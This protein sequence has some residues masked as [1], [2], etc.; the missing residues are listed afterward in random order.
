[1]GGQASCGREAVGTR[2]SRGL[3]LAADSRRNSIRGKPSCGSSSVAVLFRPE[4]TCKTYGLIH[5]TQVA[6]AS[7]RLSS[8][9]IS[10]CAARHC[11]VQIKL[12]HLASPAGPDA[13]VFAEVARICPTLA[14]RRVLCKVREHVY[15][16]GCVHSLIERAA[17][18][19][20][21]TR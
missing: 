12:C 11:L 14:L 15:G 16:K 3:R 21:R 17:A 9:F 20:V 1:M 2:G 5:T 13:Q 4:T 10:M 8:I 7:H 18:S 19:V 6:L